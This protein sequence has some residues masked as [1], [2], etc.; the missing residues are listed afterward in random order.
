[1]SS[2]VKVTKQ[3]HN[4][5]KYAN[6]RNQCA[7]AINKSGDVLLMNAAY[8]KLG[9][10]RHVEVFEDGKDGNK[11]A[12]RPSTSMSDYT[13]TI[14]KRDTPKIALRPFVQAHNMIVEGNAAVYM[15]SIEGGFL[16]IDLGQS[17]IIL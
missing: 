14:G 8:E 16:V 5:S 10:P 15:A 7:I 1:M 3:D 4:H 2:W 9:K 6:F 13:V 11:I 12:F 17:P